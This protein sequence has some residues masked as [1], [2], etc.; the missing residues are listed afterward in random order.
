[1]LNLR[2][3]ALGLWV[4]KRSGSVEEAIRR[5]TSV[6]SNPISLTSHNPLICW[7]P[8]PISCILLQLSPSTQSTCSPIEDTSSYRHGL[9]S[10]EDNIS[11][12]PVIEPK[13]A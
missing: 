4:A 5:R 13:V 10:P 9:T 8:S 2:I 3:A 11:G 7:Q 1:M 12:F 6:S